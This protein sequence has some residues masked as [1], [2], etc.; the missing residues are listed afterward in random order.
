M[1]WAQDISGRFTFLKS[2]KLLFSI[3]CPDAARAAL[4]HPLKVYYCHK[5]QTLV[6][7]GTYTERVFNGATDAQENEKLK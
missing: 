2:G 1:K 6:I 3:P 4:L 7:E 5:G